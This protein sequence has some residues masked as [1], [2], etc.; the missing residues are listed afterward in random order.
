V[1]AK[2]ALFW[3]SPPY[4]PLK[5]N[6]I[7]KDHFASIFRDEKQANQESNKLCLL[8]AS[9]WFLA[10][11]IFQPW[12]WRRHVPL[13]RRLTCSGLQ[14]IMSQ[15]TELGIVV[16]LHVSAWAKYRN[17]HVRYFHGPVKKEFSSTTPCLGHIVRSVFPRNIKCNYRTKTWMWRNL[18]CWYCDMSTRRWTMRC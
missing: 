10:W 15:K 12:R 4:S 2:S 11:F 6:Y 7:S 17:K 18:R 8:L 14:D 16:V 3:D 13:K 9:C 1:V 5:L